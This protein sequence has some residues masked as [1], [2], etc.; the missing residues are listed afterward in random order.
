MYLYSDG[1]G[2]LPRLEEFLDLHIEGTQWICSVG[3]YFI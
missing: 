3:V 1:V 2:E